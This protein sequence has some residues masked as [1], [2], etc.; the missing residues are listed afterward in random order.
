MLIRLQIQN[1]ALI[2]NLTLEFDPRL[3][4]LTGETGAGKSILIDAICF[5]LGERFEGLKS[6]AGKTCSVEAVFEIPKTL[7]KDETLSQFVSEEDD[8]LILRREVTAEGRG[9][10]WI[11]NRAATAGVL[12]QAGSLMLDIHGQHDHQLLLDPACHLDFID[13]LAKNS[14]ILEAYKKV[15]TAYALLLKN[16]EE[17]LSL[18]D[19][20]E[21]EIDLLQ[22]QIKE[23]EGP[24]FE[25]DEE[26]ELKNER[27]RLANAEKLYEN[28]GR[29]L[30]YLNDE[31][32]NVSNLLGRAAKDL[33]NFTRLDPSMES[34]KVDFEN[35]QLGLEEIIRT[36]KDYQENLSFDED[37]L[38]EI[39]K[40]LDQIELVKRK[41][42]GSLA[43]AL[44]FLKEAKE[45]YDKLV[46]GALYEKEIDKEISKLM[47]QLKDLSAQ[48]TERRKK[49]GA[50]LKKT[51]ESELKDLN[52][53]NA[54]FECSATKSDFASTGADTLEFFVSLNPGHEPAPLS[55]IISGGEASRVMLAMKKALMKVDPMPTLIFDEID[56]N[57]GG[58]L[59]QITGQKLKEI[60]EERQVLLITHLPQIASFAD[61]HFKVSKKTLKGQTVVEYE[62]LEGEDRVKE[63]AQMMSGKNETEISRKH[64]EE[65]LK[66]AK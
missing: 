56:A 7:R 40:R 24:R 62:L 1:F 12:K 21:R 10:V 19:K 44:E 46:N 51:I 47:P 66:V 15:Y 63:L 35:A 17:L 32:A 20:R 65:M 41:Y 36:L 25:P 9:R 18:Q 43:A 8:V 54:R 61:R 30:Q 33:N 14:E 3:N 2:Q 55:K 31:E 22:Y 13:R 49:A 48:L 28:A 45:K 11:N 23:I 58:R 6:A 29:V 34:L 26:E 52:I 50:S 38:A 59:G 37:R 4:V 57:I 42:G 60:S 5:A 16:K 64:A 53:P 39:D 27:I